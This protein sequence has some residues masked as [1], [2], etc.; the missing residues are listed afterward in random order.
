MSLFPGFGYPVAPTITLTSSKDTLTWDSTR[1]IMDRDHPSLAYVL[2]AQVD[3]EGHTA[4]SVKYFGAIRRVDSLIFLL[5]QKIQTDSIY[6]DRTT[7][8]VT[9]DHGRHDDLHGGWQAHGDACHGCRHVPFFA[10]GPDI[11]AG[12]VIETVRDHIDIAPTVAYLLGFHAPLAQ[13]TIMSEMLVAPPPARGGGSHSGTHEQNL[14]GAVGVARS[15]SVAAGRTGIHVAFAAGEP[16]ITEVLYVRS[17]DSGATWEPARPLFSR[18][19]TEYL[20]TAITLFADS[21]LF[22]ATTGYRY[23]EVDSS[24]GW[25]LEGRRSI[26]RG[27]TWR[28]RFCSTR[29]PRSAH[30][31]PLHPPGQGSVSQP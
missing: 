3:A 22:A 15:P 2:F 30:N 9:S 19:G 6:R 29:S 8:L 10:I 13:G 24:Y 20:G 25:I 11:R 5:W 12:E 26:D 23:F 7:M 1:V 28:R 21:C 4:D 17:T 18:P 27:A 14:S 31:P 16:G